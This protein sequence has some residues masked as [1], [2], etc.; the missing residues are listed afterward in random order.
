MHH[1]ALSATACEQG[2]K[3][4]ADQ[5]PTGWAT[6]TE[7]QHQMHSLPQDTSTDISNPGCNGPLQPFQPAEQ[8]LA[9]VPTNAC[10]FTPTSQRPRR[11]KVHLSDSLQSFL[12]TALSNS[13]SSNPTSQANAHKLALPAA[14]AAACSTVPVNIAAFKKRAQ[15]NAAAPTAMT[16]IDAEQTIAE[17][18]PAAALA[19]QA[20]KR[21]VLTPAV[22]IVPSFAKRPKLAG[23]AK[24]PASS[25]GQAIGSRTI[26]AGSKA[27]AAGIK[28]NAVIKKKTMAKKAAGSKLMPTANAQIA[29]PEAAAAAVLLHSA[30]P[31]AAAAVLA[32]NALPATAGTVACA[33]VT[34]GTLAA[35][36][37]AMGL[38]DQPVTALPPAAAATPAAPTKAPRQRKKADD[39]DLAAVE[40]K[41]L[42]KH[43]AGSLNDLSI[44]ELKCFLKARKATVGGKKAD[45]IARLQPLLSTA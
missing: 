13:N 9:A 37:S 3:S 22:A 7:R 10:A 24:A 8:L 28:D 34:A 2:N 26:A 11:P 21:P 16:S 44:P 32:T 23:P 29:N 41:V 27:A 14:T 18:L 30:T 19:L 20:A 12:N 43:A 1:N 38:P 42:E 17:P 40:K 35:G 45:L 25:K 31:E 4:G 39:I 33:G 15:P 5:Q 6:G 36:Q